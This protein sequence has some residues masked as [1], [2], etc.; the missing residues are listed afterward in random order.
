M[1]QTF[2]AINEEQ[3]KLKKEHTD[4]KDLFKVLDIM[5]EMN[6]KYYL[7]GGWGVDVLTGKQNRQHRDID[8]DFDADFTDDL[9]MKLHEIGY[10]S[11]QIG[12]R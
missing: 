5:D 3:N 1:R 7:D 6:I 10:E 2:I 11:S 8:L 9:L 4:E 12:C